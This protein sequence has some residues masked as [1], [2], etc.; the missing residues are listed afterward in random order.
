M[1]TIVRLK[2]E[3][4]ADGIP[5][6]IRA[7][8][9]E[10]HAGRHIPGKGHASTGSHAVTSAVDNLAL[11]CAGCLVTKV[12]GRVEENGVCA[13]EASEIAYRAYYSGRG[14]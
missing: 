6:A 12:A 14:R 8:S 5:E 11:C 9:G 3:N 1:Q 2:G 13:G 10:G 4:R 7:A